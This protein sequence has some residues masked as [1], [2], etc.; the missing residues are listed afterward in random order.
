MTCAHVVN[1]ATMKI[2]GVASVDVSLNRA[3]ATI[4]L[5]P[6][7]SVGLAKLA[8]AIREK[9][10]TVP[11]AEIQ[12]RGTLAK[13]HDRW[14]LRIPSSGEALEVA[15][16]PDTASRLAEHVGG[17]ITLRA[18]TAFAKDRKPGPLAILEWK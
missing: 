11:A 6:G 9:G 17:E 7:N 16:D 4:K 3:L 10:Y 5:K 14:V 15:A 1:V 8:H 12:V 13:V 2:E 18:K